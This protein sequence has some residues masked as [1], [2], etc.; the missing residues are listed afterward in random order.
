MKTKTRTITAENRGA[1]MDW[2]RQ[3][4]YEEKVAEYKKQAD[5]ADK[6]M[7]RLEK[8]GKKGYAME[9]A[10]GDIAILGGTNRFRGKTL[11]KRGIIDKAMQTMTEFLSAKSSTITG[12]SDI[13]K[14]RIKTLKERYGIELNEETIEKFFM[15]D[16]WHDLEEDYD[17]GTALVVVGSALA[18]LDDIADRIKKSEN[19]VQFVDKDIIKEAIASSDNLMKTD[20]NKLS[21]TAYIDN[22]LKYIEDTR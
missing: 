10:K 4:S 6:R 17:S 5:K 21:S 2:F 7:L 3:L 16:L 18:S 19:I 14:A 12:I 9:Y 11:Q 22:F 8:S 13:D 1:Y 20:K 15:S